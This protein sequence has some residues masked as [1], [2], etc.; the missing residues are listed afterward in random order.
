MKLKIWLKSNDVVTGINMLDVDKT[1]EIIGVH[2]VTNYLTVLYGDK[3]V[4]PNIVNSTVEVISNM[5]YNLYIDKWKLNTIS[6]IDDLGVGVD[7]KILTNNNNTRNSLKDLVIN[8]VNSLNAF[9]D[10]IGSEVDSQDS[11]TTESDNTTDS[12]D[13][14]VVNKSLLGLQRQIKFIKNNSLIENICKDIIDVVT[15]KIY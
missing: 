8:R 1:L 9:N 14:E 3:I 7:R 4:P 6:I 10:V 5:I 2:N 11:N 15:I 12:G 13:K